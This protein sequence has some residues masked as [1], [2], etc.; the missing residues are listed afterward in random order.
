MFELPLCGRLLACVA[1]GVLK[2][3]CPYDLFNV[4]R[5]R[6]EEGDIG[7]ERSSKGVFSCARCC[8]GFA[9]VHQLYRQTYLMG[10]F[11]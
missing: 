7:C 3:L 6:P 9:S 8:V 4:T 5:W 11:R 1:L 2:T 10:N